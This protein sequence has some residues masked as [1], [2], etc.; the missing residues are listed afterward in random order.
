MFL[1][2]ILRG[3]IVK[4]LYLFSLW[5]AVISD[6]S[7]LPSPEDIYF[8][9]MNLR[10]TLMWHAGKDTPNDTHYTV[11]YAIYG[12]TVDVGGKKVRWRVKK[13]CVDIPQLWC[14]LSNETTDLD[15]NYYARVKAVSTN[16]SS[17]WKISKRFDPKSDTSLGPPLVKL[18]GKG[19]TVTVKLKG[20]MR[21]KTGNMSKEYSMFKFLPKM[22]YTLFVNDYRSNKTDHFTLE[23]RSFKYEQLGYDTKYCFAAKAQFL[24]RSSNASEWQCLTTP[25]DPFFDQLLGMLL[26]V[27]VPSAIC[28]FVLIVFGYLVYH[29]VSG[30]K[31][32]S[33]SSLE[34]LG[35]YNTPRT[36][37]P[38]QAVTVNLILVNMAKP[39]SSPALIHQPKVMPQLTYAAQQAPC[40]QDS[41]VVCSEN[42]SD[43]G[44]LEPLDYCF[45]GAAPEMPQIRGSE[46]SDSDE[47]LPLC[48]NRGNPYVAQR[49]APCSQERVGDVF[50]GICLG[51]DPKTGLFM[52]PLEDLDVQR[53]RGKKHHEVGSYA[54]QNFS[55]REIPEGDA[56]EDEAEEGQR[57]GI[58]LRGTTGYHTEFI[59]RDAQPLQIEPVNLHMS[60]SLIPQESNDEDG[61]EVNCVDW[62]PTTGIL[63]IPL[64]SM[65]VPE[66]E[67][68]VEEVVESERVEILASVLVRQSS[69]GSEGDSDL[70]RLQN[71]WSLQLMDD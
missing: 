26:G 20:P 38:E 30:N 55:L 34:I 17:K 32:Q 42:E 1:Q 36:L 57:D 25:K 9:S 40:R 28:L 37:H 44:Q 53:A 66:T 35:H 68:A 49:H 60:Q 59:R 11:E 23:S 2:T 16:K 52:I 64:L 22:A 46:A 47:T 18:V 39:T 63:Q 5:T 41:Q 19:N 8:N 58:H 3:G 65:S 43:E 45:V 51:R 48:L 14:D 33:P 6:R 12:D 70:V 61:C 69:Q 56:C 71:A 10:N 13:Q 62:S 21:W 4:Y 31:Q 54:P 15:E 27:A 29:F 24:S 67:E 7:F 50:T